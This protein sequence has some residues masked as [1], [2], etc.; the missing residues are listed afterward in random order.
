MGALDACS[1]SE[2]MHRRPRTT[3]ME[4][5][6]ILSAWKKTGQDRSVGDARRAAAAAE[7]TV[8]DRGVVRSEN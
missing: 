1:V 3:R 4:Y 2:K 7:R 6:A 8:N 5:F